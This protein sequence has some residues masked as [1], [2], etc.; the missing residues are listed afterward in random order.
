[1]V[2][3]GTASVGGAMVAV[4]WAGDFSGQDGIVDDIRMRWRCNA[5][6]GN[7]VGWERSPSMTS[8]VRRIATSIEVGGVPDFDI[9][10]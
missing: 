7:W 8:P 4:R 9:L 6:K 2:Y 10:A 3:G 1:M 5:I